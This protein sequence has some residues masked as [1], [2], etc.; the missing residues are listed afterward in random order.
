[1]SA[2]EPDPTTIVDTIEGLTPSYLTDLLAADLDGGRVVGVTAEPI[3]TDDGMVALLYRLRLDLD[4]AG[5]DAPGSVVAKVPNEIEEIRATSQLVGIYEREIRAYRELCPGLPVRTP[6]LHIGL[7][8]PDPAERAQP[9][10]SWLFERLPVRVLQRAL[11]GIY[12]AAKR[13]DRRYLLIMEDLV[14]AEAGSQTDAPF[15]RFEAAVDV[16]AQLHATHWEG[17][18]TDGLDWVPAFGD[19]RLIQ[20]YWRRHRDRYRARHEDVV[21]ERWT[22]RLD[23]LD[24]L[25]PM[26]VRQLNSGPTTICH[27]DPRMTNFMFGSDGSVTLIDWQ[28]VCVGAAGWDLA[29][30]LDGGLSDSLWPQRGELVERYRSELARHGVTRSA[31]ELDA[32]LARASLAVAFRMVVSEDITAGDDVGRSPVSEMVER[33]VTRM[34][35]ALPLG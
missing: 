1:M 14:D 10:V 11:G 12:A 24:E 20:A 5:P 33:M 34:A 32:E 25:Y 26:L 16:L 2:T 17:R 35:D 6:R 31:E 27:G 8:D 15:E 21:G 19:V 28:I 7:F 13:S 30:L 3:G 9:A 23:E 18:D 29:Y 4:G 22:A